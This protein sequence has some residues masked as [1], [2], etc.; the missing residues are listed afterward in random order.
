MPERHFVPEFRFGGQKS[1][2]NTL[3]LKKLKNLNEATQQEKS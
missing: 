2:F 1:E 3:K